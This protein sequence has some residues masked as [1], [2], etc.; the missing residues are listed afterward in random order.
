M[1]A[2]GASH[3]PSLLAFSAIFYG[4]TPIRQT[5]NIHN[6]ISLLEILYRERLSTLKDISKKGISKTTETIDKQSINYRESTEFFESIVENTSDFIFQTTLT[7]VFTYANPASEKIA[8]YDSK[9]MIGKR[10]TKFVPKKELPKYFSKIKEMAQGKKIDSFETYVIH[11]DGHLVPVEFSGNMIKIRN[12]SY[13]VGVMRNITDRKRTEEKL[14]LSEKRF[15]DIAFSMADWIWEVDKDGIY[16]FASGRVKEILGYTPEEIIGKTPFDFMSKDGAKRVGEIFREIASEKKPI[17]DLENWNLTKQGENI[18]LLTNGIPLLDESGNL[19]GYRGVDRDIT[20]R[21]LAE[22]D[23]R[24]TKEYLQKIINSASEIII[25]FDTSNRVT[26][27]NKT[28][29]QITGYKQREVLGRKISYLSIF[30]NSGDLT[31]YINDVFNGHTKSFEDVTL[32]SKTG[33]RKLVRVLGSIVKGD[34]NENIGVLLVGR[35]ITRDS[36]L[37]GKLIPGNSYIC[38]DENAE[39]SL[40]LFKDLAGSGF[41]GLYVTRVNPEGIKDMFPLV[42]VEVILL[43]EDKTNGFEYVRDT[44]GLVAKIKRFAEEK[45]RPLILLDRVDFL[46][47]I[48]SFEGFIKALYRII[49]IFESHNA[50]LLV[51]L[52]PN[53]VD[54]RQL[55]LIKEEL[56]PLPSQKIED[57]EL[58]DK[59][60]GILEFI[61]RQNRNNILVSYSKIGDEFSISKVTTNKYL[62][63]LGEK[64]LVFIK[65]NGRLKTV[66]VTEKGE[67]LI[68]RR[69][70]I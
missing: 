54:K 48:F 49:D 57:I 25:S 69:T 8:D 51:R 29:E 70:V 31:G 43:S 19:I 3:I 21:K 45:S 47:S 4:L 24:R 46:I 38:I 62:N 66:H 28:A 2:K 67:T 53:F 68:Q 56:L 11:K 41:D 33:A 6:I 60:Y 36:E 64:N 7:G 14:R 63:S 34:M 16:T 61:H 59:L 44:D 30:V 5:F 12:K 26:T 37:H 50:V 22:G 13:I 40:I 10:F 1:P 42:D 15:K 27:W 35:D 18:C 17:V 58:E 39:S 55:E 23:I 65:K 9:E 52:N 32:Q 20:K